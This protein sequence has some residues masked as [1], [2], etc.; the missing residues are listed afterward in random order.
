MISLP[1]P[2]L[3]WFCFPSLRQGFDPTI[4]RVLLPLFLNL[5]NPCFSKKNWMVSLC[6]ARK[7]LS[8]RA[9]FIGSSFSGAKRP[10]LDFLECGR[11]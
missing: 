4:G 7:I 3:S 10:L 8:R 2:S 6:R 9:G 5:E 11:F 1:L